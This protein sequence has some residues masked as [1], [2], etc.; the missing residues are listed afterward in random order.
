MWSG[1][2]LEQ[3][4]A[5]T[6][7]VLMDDNNSTLA[8]I[9]SD[10]AITLQVESWPKPVKIAQASPVSSVRK[11]VAGPEQIAVLFENG[12]VMLAEAHHYDYEGKI[13]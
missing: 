10:G 3:E 4:R 5:D 8:A 9:S 1:D 7:T 13:R 12:E 6:N 2:S 11:I